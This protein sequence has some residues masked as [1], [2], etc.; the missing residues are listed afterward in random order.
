MHNFLKTLI[1]PTH[2]ESRNWRAVHFSLCRGPC[3]LG[4][5]GCH[6]EVELIQEELKLYY[7]QCIEHVYLQVQKQNIMWNHLISSLWQELWRVLC[8]KVWGGGGEWLLHPL[9]SSFLFDYHTPVVK[10]SFS[11]Q[12]STTVK[13]KDGTCNFH[14]E[15]A[16]H[17]LTLKLCLPC[18]L[19]KYLLNNLLHNMR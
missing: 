3:L 11:P 6:A 2:P 4:L 14:Q 13:I 15:S 1:K 8:Q 18:R 5:V 17:L 10:I 16:E 7:H 12:T 9:P 19:L